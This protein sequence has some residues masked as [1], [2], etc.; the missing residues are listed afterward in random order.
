M[1]LIRTRDGFDLHCETA[2]NPNGEALLLVTGLGGNATFWAE[3]APRFGAGFRTITYDHRGTGRSSLPLSGYSLDQMAADAL[4]VLDGLGIERA[5]VV[6]HSTG[7]CIGQILAIDQ[8]ERVISLVASSSWTAADPYFRRL[9]EVRKRALQEGGPTTYVR[10]GTLFQYPP[11]W[12]TANMA[13][14][15][16][17]E[18]AT[19][20]AFPPSDIV[21]GKIDAILEFDRRSDLHRIRVPTLV[22]AATDDVICPPYFSRALAAAIPDARLEILRSGGHFCPRT[23]PDEY[24][25]NLAM[26]LRD[27]AGAA[28]RPA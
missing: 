20:A 19:L 6:G 16:I 15:E 24:F 8:P 5:H 11:E 21:L 4:A 7:G 22:N 14:I 23:R 9:F 26:F 25:E 18:A 3:Q 27:V 17:A 28:D 10:C 13:A 2:G 1:P 12:I